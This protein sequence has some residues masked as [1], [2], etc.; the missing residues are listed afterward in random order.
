MYFVLRFCFSLMLIET[1]PTKTTFLP[2][3]DRLLTRQPSLCRRAFELDE[4]FLP[5]FLVP[6]S[7]AVARPQAE[8]ALERSAAKVLGELARLHVLPPGPLDDLVL[9]AILFLDAVHV[10]FHV[11]GF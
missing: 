1:P 6:T 3:A 8:L 5:H 4:L 7:G 9:L 2:D 11:L 10:L